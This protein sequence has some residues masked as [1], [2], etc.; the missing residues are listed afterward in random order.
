MKKVI[1]VGNI[2][3]IMGNPYTYGLTQNYIFK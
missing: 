2:Q 3:F 1:N